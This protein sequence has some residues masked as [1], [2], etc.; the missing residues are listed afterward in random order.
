MSQAEVSFKWEAEQYWYVSRE[1]KRQ[2]INIGSPITCSWCE[3][4]SEG[5]PIKL[6][7]GYKKW[8]LLCERALT[9]RWNR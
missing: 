2:N 9:A 3:E 4:F 1:I 6:A 5:N 7:R 8:E